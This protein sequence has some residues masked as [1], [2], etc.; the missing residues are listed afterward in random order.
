MGVTLDNFSSWKILNPGFQARHTSP[1][2][3]IAVCY[4]LGSVKV[5]FPSAEKS[6]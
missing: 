1:D 6:G 3:I 5:S 2:V 4:W